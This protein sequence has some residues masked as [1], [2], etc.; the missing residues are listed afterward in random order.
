MVSRSTASQDTQSKDCFLPSP[1]LT[2]LIVSLVCL[3]SRVSRETELVPSWL[4]G[5]YSKSLL[6]L[7]Y[8]SDTQHS[9]D[10]STLNFLED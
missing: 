9:E 6:S 7:C 10:T 1:L 8:L 3:L 2:V 5:H 4:R